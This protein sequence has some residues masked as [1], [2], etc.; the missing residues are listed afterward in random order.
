MPK[1]GCITDCQCP[2]GEYCKDGHCSVLYCDLQEQLGFSAR[3]IPRSNGQNP[4]VTINSTAILSCD[5]P[6]QVF[7]VKG[8]NIGSTLVV[9]SKKE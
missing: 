2:P 4:T 3:R 7:K 1:Q 6:G 5:M 8:G 9:S